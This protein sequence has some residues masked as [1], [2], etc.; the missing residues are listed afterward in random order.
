MAM[1]N[2]KKH[3]LGWGLVVLSVSIIMIESRLSATHSASSN[4]AT[5]IAEPLQS[6]DLKLVTQVFESTSVVSFQLSANE[7]GRSNRPLRRLGDNGHVYLLIESER[8]LP[9][10]IEFDSSG[11]RLRQIDVGSHPLLGRLSVDASKVF[12]TDMVVDR[13][14]VIY[15]SGIAFAV[16]P[17]QRSA[18]FILMFNETGVPLKGI[19]TGYY[20]NLK[21]ALDER[22]SLY[23]YGEVDSNR[24]DL[25]ENYA[26][27]KYNPYG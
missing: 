13:Q 1:S 19:D 10:I 4:P 2:L 16:S 9:Q 14:G 20:R 5:G 24:A 23:V 26:I 6:G 22:G 27:R 21:L 17:S 18:N 25:G 11:T 15:L 3:C 7:S 8:S 12:W